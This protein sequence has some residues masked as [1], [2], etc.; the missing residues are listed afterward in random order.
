[1]NKLIEEQKGNQKTIESLQNLVKTL[2]DRPVVRN[3]G[4][5]EVKGGVKGDMSG[6]DEGSYWGS[7]RY[8]GSAWNKF[9]GSDLDDWDDGG[10]WYENH[11]SGTRRGRSQGA[12]GDGWKKDRMGMKGA[13]K[14]GGNGDGWKGDRAEMRGN[15]RAGGKGKQRVAENEGKEH[16]GK[17]SLKP[18]R[19]ENEWGRS[20]EWYNKE[21]DDEGDAWM[22][23]AD[24]E[25]NHDAFD[26][27]N[28]SDYY[29]N[30]PRYWEPKGF[31][32][33]RKKNNEE[34]SENLQRYKEEWLGETEYGEEKEEGVNVRGGMTAEEEE[35]EMRLW[36]VK[37][38]E[39]TEPAMEPGGKGKKGGK[40][41]NNK[42]R[43]VS[44]NRT[45]T[46][47]TKVKTTDTKPRGRPPNSSKAA[48]S[49][50]TENAGASRQSNKRTLKVTP[51][52]DGSQMEDTTNGGNGGLGGGD[53]IEPNLADNLAGLAEA[54]PTVG[55]EEEGEK[56][57]E[58]EKQV[59]E[60]KKNGEE[61]PGN[62]NS[63]RVYQER[64]VSS[65]DWRQ[66]NE[67]WRFSGGKWKKNPNDISQPQ[68][69]WDDLTN[70]DY[71]VISD[72][73]EGKSGKENK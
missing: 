25:T 57:E 72:L 61:R 52:F 63:Q 2:T 1:M 5:E 35:E 42:G 18:Q 68:Y 49:K 14:F 58:A 21:D 10:N 12:G 44:R 17:G 26:T 73:F 23:D 30:C 41:S 27:S 24:R 66:S 31:E 56:L 60:E 19:V 29:K 43:S 13:G 45:P 36:G 59:E 69:D 39:A 71:S 47:N 67:E 46:K 15:S 53:K 28:W 33:I 51:T 22:G 7:K 20:S 50:D 65:G 16:H 54:D 64:A 6:G 55:I 4:A 38:K 3:G 9:G 40:R 11:G 70:D 48:G 37:R 32:A 34:Y 62:L 8:K